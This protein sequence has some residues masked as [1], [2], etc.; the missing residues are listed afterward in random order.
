MPILPFE[1]PAPEGLDA[2]AGRIQDSLDAN[3]V[4][5]YTSEPPEA[6]HVAVEGAGDLPDSIRRPGQ[7]IVMKVLRREK[8]A[9]VVIKGNRRIEAEAIKRIIK[10]QKG[11]IY[12][13][14]HIQ[15]DLKSIHKMGYFG[16][17]RADAEST[18][19]GKVVTFRVSENETIRKIGIRGHKSFDDEKIKE[20]LR[21]RPGSIL[22]VNT[23]VGDLREVEN[24]YKEKG[25]HHVK[26]T[27]ETKSVSE[28]RA[29]IDFVIEEGERVFI[30]AISFEGNNSYDDDALKD[31]MKTEG[32]GFFS[33]LTASGDLD[34]EVL[35]QDISKIA[36]YYHNHGYIQARVAEPHFTYDG[37]WIH[38]DIKIEEGPRFK[39]GKVDIEGDLIQPKEELLDKMKIN[40][41][42]FYNRE[43]IREDI[44]ILGDVYSDAGYAYADISPRIDQDL[45]EFKAD[46]IYVIN[47]G[48]LVYFE[49]IMISGNTK[50]RDKVIRRELKVYEQEVFCGKSLR[51]GVR[52]LYRLD[53]FEDIKVNTSKGS[54]D[55]R[56]ILRLDVAE[57]PT[58][59]FSFGGGYSSV[60]GLFAMASISQRNLFGRGQILGLNAHLGKI[61]TTYTFRFTEPWLFDIPLTAGFD[62][63]NT[64]KDYDTYDK[65]SS[66][67]TIRFGYPVFDYTRLSLSYNYDKA[68]I[69]DIDTDKATE[70]I[71]EMEGENVGNTITAVLRRDSRDRI[72][73]PTEGSDNSIMVKHAGAPMGGDIGFTKYIANSGW[74]TPLFWNTVGVLHGRAGCIV[75]VTDGKM[76]DWERFY[77]GGMNSV[78]GYGWRDISAEDPEGNEIGGD[79]M[80]QF[81]LEFLFPIAR[82]SGLMGVLFYDTGSVYGKGEHMDLAELRSSAGFGFRWYSPIGPIRLEYG[83][84]LDDKEDRQG[85]GGLEFTMG[86]AF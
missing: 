86:M 59:V 53:F 71:K 41:E 40:K 45:K 79:K 11:D 25:Y 70:S 19:Q 78:R 69:K 51:R 22:N 57:K 61:S 21:T 72:F 29:D 50:T 65:D 63:Y 15:N 48:P 9:E 17:V 75:D 68:D 1:A 82:E 80:V 49:K 83:Y 30:K 84:I 28:N 24:L 64:T 2:V 44:L 52:N 36:A 27:H 47:K 62:L 73:N 5:S 10:T 18:P 4:E 8:V 58:G 74:Y 13:E 31:L 14:K 55:D 42:Q 46:I 32:K 66:G 33:W 60:D 16:D 56:L 67:G 26:V 38:I 23:L 77:L 81:N 35:D 39:V 6:L 37:R 43:I 34:R 54:A 12:S 7:G 3:I 76:P 20:V 85:E